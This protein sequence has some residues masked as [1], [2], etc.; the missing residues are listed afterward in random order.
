V[1]PSITPAVAVQVD[2]V[3]PCLNEAAALP[4]VLA[5]LPPGYRAVVVDNGSTDGSA[6]IARSLGALVVT[7]PRRGFGSACAAGLAAAAAPLV[8]FCD[9]DASLDLRELPSLTAAVVS[10]R[11]DLVLGR[12]RPDTWG[13]WPVHARLANRVLARRLRART[14]VQLQ[15]LGPM[16]VGSRAR[17]LALHIADRR[18][19]YPLEMVLRAA[20]AGW[21]I[22]ELDVSYRPRTGR[23][24][25]TGTVQGTVNAVR[26]MRR[27]LAEAPR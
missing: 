24:K 8:A 1:S 17:L 14:G 21:R 19:G 15:D 11:A 4:S 10:G 22:T 16:R 2:V 6:A 3:L 20:A 12:R 7:E 26:D 25:V 18:S 23:S 13:A 9:A 5:G 27:V